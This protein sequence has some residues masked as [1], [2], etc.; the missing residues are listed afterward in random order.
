M[1]YGNKTGTHPLLLDVGL[2]RVIEEAS[3]ASVSD[4]INTAQSYSTPDEIVSHICLLV[5]LFDL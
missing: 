2:T 3:N 5:C 4:W 1:E